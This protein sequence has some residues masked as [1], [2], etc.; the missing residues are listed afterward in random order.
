MV[1]DR[2]IVLNPTLHVVL[3][4]PRIAGNIAAIVRLCV[5][6]QCALHVCGPLVFDTNDKTKWRAGLDYFFGARLHFHRNLKRCLDLLGGNPWLLEVGG[7]KTPWQSS[8]MAGS[9][10]VLGPETASIDREIMESY[11]ER[12]I[13]LPQLGP[14]RS[15]NLAQ[16]ASI[17][18]FEAVRQQ[19]NT[20]IK[21]VPD[22]DGLVREPHG[23]AE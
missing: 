2:H 7:K 8:L 17:I 16:C 9:V 21:A 15:L 19:M 23:M 20:H 13:S 5:A 18:C 14:V 22:I 4:R 11:P 6:T 3:D 12:V 1:I 10:V